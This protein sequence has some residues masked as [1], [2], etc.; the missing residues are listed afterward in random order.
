MSHLR[1]LLCRVDD[2]QPPEAMVELHRIDLPAVDPQQLAPAAALDE[3]EARAVATGQAMARQ[4]LG[5]QWQEL[6]RQV[7]AETQRLS[8]PSG[9]GAVMGLPSSRWPPRSAWWRC[10]GKCCLIASGASTRC[11]ETPGCRPTRGRS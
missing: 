8:P 2:D 5:Q 4:L 9:A 7:A 6:D 1:L 11:R 3:L 10:D